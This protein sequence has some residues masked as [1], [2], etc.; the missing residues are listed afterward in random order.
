M[1]RS[2]PTTTPGCGGQHWSL[3]VDGERHEPAA[4]LKP[5]RSRDHPRSAGLDLG[6]QPGR[7]LMQL[8]P[9]QSRQD[10]V[11][12]LA[13]DRAGGEPDRALAA[14]PGLEPGNPTGAPLRFPLRESPSSSKTGPG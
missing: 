13:A 1:P 5:G 7:V 6:D 14:V 2:T 10:Y 8:D 12:G 11:S 9:A 4:P 3:R